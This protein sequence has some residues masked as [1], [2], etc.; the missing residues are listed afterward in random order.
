MKKE[1]IRQIFRYLTSGGLAVFIYYA[2]LYCFTE[3]LQIW[4]IASATTATIMAF[5]LNF[6]LHKFWTFN[7]YDLKSVPKQL[8]WYTIMKISLSLANLI[9]LYCLVEA[10]KMHY[11]LAS[12]ILTAGSSVIS[13][14]L[15]NKI[16]KNLI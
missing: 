9:L 15:T 14:I 16:F 10:L 5:L 2:I 8:T 7:N 13:Y 6:T 3:L 12:I 11:L 1:K 4:Y